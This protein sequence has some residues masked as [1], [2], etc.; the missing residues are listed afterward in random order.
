[1]ARRQRPHRLDSIPTPAKGLG[2]IRLPRHHRRDDTEYGLVLP[3]RTENGLA[4]GWEDGRHPQNGFVTCEVLD[5][6]LPH[7]PAERVIEFYAPSL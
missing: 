1:M 6:T 2:G 4:L 5:D 7:G 3:E